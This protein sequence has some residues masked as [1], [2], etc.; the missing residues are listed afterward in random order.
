MATTYP[1]QLFIIWGNKVSIDCREALQEVRQE[2][3]LPPMQIHE[4]G[5][6]RFIFTI[7]DHSGDK[8]QSV[9]VNVGASAIPHLIEQTRL[10]K[11]RQIVSSVNKDAAELSPA[12]TEQLQFG[13]FKGK[14]P[15]Q[16]LLDGGDQK[17]L[18]EMKAMLEKNL[19][20]YPNNKKVIDAIDDAIT[21]KNNGALK[22]AAGASHSSIDVFGEDYKYS[23][24]ETSDGYRTISGISIKYIPGRL[25]PWRVE[26]TNYEAPMMKSADGQLRPEV[27]KA[28]NKRC[29]GINISDKDWDYV[30]DCVGGTKR[31]FESMVFPSLYARAQDIDK[32]LRTSWQKSE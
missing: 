32:E 18:L 23:R 28:R 21:L 7:T 4:G 22:P 29:F 14:T 13:V 15:A 12:H 30:I 16:A 17:K 26:V 2:K 20:A 1:R 31:L 11:M 19:S 24:N 8:P 9:S 3:D 27:S 10:T 6:S 5:L 25:Y